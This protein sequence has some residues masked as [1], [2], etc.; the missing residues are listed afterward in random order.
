MCVSIHRFRNSRHILILHKQ[1]KKKQKNKKNR[2][3]FFLFYR[4]AGLGRP[5]RGRLKEEDAA[6]GNT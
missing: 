5:N 1:E 2:V 4:N 3:Q 6:R